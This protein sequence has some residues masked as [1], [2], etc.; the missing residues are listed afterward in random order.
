MKRPEEFY[1]LLDLSERAADSRKYPTLVNIGRAM[2]RNKR[3]GF[4]VESESRFCRSKVTSGA[5]IEQAV[6]HGVANEEIRSS[7]IP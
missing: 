2:Q 3:E 1:M 6:Y 4:L 5:Q 7:G